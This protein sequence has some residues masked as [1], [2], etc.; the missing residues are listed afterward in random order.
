MATVQIGNL[1]FNYQQST[2]G[3]LQLADVANEEPDGTAVALDFP[4]GDPNHI[5]ILFGQFQYGSTPIPTDPSLFPIESGTVTG[6]TEVEVVNGVNLLIEQLTGFT[7]QPLVGGIAGGSAGE[8][9]NLLSGND[10]LTMGSANATVTAGTGN[11]TL[12]LGS[13]AVSV[14]SMG[15]DTITAGAGPATVNATGNALVIANGPLAFLNTGQGSATVVG[16]NG[17]APVTIFGGQGGGL[18]AGSKG[19]GNV[20]AAGTQ[21]SVIFGEGNNDIMAA[22]GSGQDLIAAGSGN[23][24]IIGVNGSGNNVFWG[25]SGS[26]IFGAGSGTDFYIAGSG[27]NTIIGGTGADFYSILKGFSSGGSVDIFGFNPGKGDALFLAGGYGA[28]EAA[29]AVAS[30]T[31]SGGV[32]MLHLS[33]NTTIKL[34]GVTNLNASN[35]L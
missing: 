14:N 6:I 35:F 33:D 21:S 18:F 25:G 24:A 3:T 31:V 15:N 13:G 26:D 29:N 17:T 2:I 10:T 20:I 16:V 23:E 5:I 32:T 7:P 19:G 11:N 22:N 4:G 30:E 9:L 12:S 27:S 28:N 34:E 1:P 8:Y